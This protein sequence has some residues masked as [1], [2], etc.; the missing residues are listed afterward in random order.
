MAGW[1]DLF[2]DRPA[3]AVA[4]N[5]ATIAGQV[6]DAR[7]GRAI[8]DAVVTIVAGPAGFTRMREALAALE[9]ANPGWQPQGQRPDRR[10]CR[11]NGGFVFV[12]LDAGGGYTLRAAAPHL[13]SRYGT[14]EISAAPGNFR[15]ALKLPP[16]CISGTLRDPA[17]L[18]VVGARVALVGGDM[19]AWTDEAGNFTLGPITK[20]TWT[21]V[22]GRPGYIAPAGQPRPTVTVGQGEAQT[23]ALVLQKK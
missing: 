14:V 7:S 20:G 9:A 16:T 19:L 8:A 3:G 13:G 15:V 23:I 6:S 21:I 17:G 1:K 5:T 18:P 2:G 10:I 12:D 4:R 22:P 11:A